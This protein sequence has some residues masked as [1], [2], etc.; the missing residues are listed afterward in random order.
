MMILHTLCRPIPL[1]TGDTNADYQINN[2]LSIPQV[3]KQ[4]PDYPLI[5][6]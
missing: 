4:P 3:T 1:P 2:E 5:L 6:D